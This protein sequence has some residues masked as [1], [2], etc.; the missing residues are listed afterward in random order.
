MKKTPSS[1]T[2]CRPFAVAKRS[3]LSLLLPGLA[4]VLPLGCG[5]EDPQTSARLKGTGSSLL[6]TNELT[7]TPD[8]S[9]SW[10]RRFTPEQI[11][12]VYSEDLEQGK[13][14]N[15]PPLFSFFE[16]QDQA[17]ELAQEFGSFNRAAEIRSYLN[18]NQDPLFLAPTRWAVAMES[19]AGWTKIRNAK[20][21]A[22]FRDAHSIDA[23]GRR[24]P[25]SIDGVI[26][27]G[28]QIH[29]ARVRIPVPV[30]S[31]NADL[32]VR[33]TDVGSVLTTSLINERPIQAP[34]VG[35]VIKAGGFRIVFEMHPYKKGF[36]VYGVTAAQ[37]DKMADQMT[38]EALGDQIGAMLNWLHGQLLGQTPLLQAQNLR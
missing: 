36:L 37:L 33:L 24:I 19:V 23:S 30:G 38:P 14:V 9:G 21:E 15:R 20:G 17:P 2:P 8:S 3:V 12:A 31:V 27:D 34:I 5:H 6:G 22:M 16:S 18:L 10:S 7:S 32:R 1:K 13:P 29:S 26:A 25:D 11:N 35:T 4:L 28:D